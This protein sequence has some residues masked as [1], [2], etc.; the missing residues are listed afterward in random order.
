MGIK[1]KTSYFK[2]KQKC[3]AAYFLMFTL[4][5]LDLSVDW[6][7]ID[8]SDRKILYLDNIE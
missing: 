6:F 1:Q 3:H 5:R 7:T 4:R 8:H 2:N